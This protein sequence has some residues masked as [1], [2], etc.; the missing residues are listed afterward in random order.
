MSNA[1]DR[2]VK[3]HSKISREVNNDDIQLVKNDSDIMFRLCHTKHGIYAGGLAVAHQQIEDNDPL[4]FFVLADGEIIIN[5]R[6]TRHTN[7]TVDSEEG[8]LSFENNKQIIVQRWN[9]CEVEYQ[10]INKDGLLSD[11][12]LESLSGKRAKIFQHEIDHFD[13]KYIF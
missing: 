4:R 8:C 13:C 10:K 9:K 12:I 7:H 5:P 2:Y 1:T 6:I 11:F 3:P